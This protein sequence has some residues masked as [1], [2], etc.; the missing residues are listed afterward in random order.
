MLRTFVRNEMLLRREDVVV[1]PHNVFNSKEAALRILET[2][3]ESIERSIEGQPQNV[4]VC[5]ECGALTEVAD[6]ANPGSCLSCGATLSAAAPARQG[7]FKCKVC[8]AT[9]TYPDPRASVPRHRMFAIEYHCARYRPRHKGR[10][11]K[12]PDA[13]DLAKY[14]EASRRWA[15]TA[16]SF[17]PNEE[18]PAGGR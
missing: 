9:N 5:P 18:I 13:D 10:F 6:R 16:P 14:A 17:V 3:A 1:T 12:K 11:F 8:G 4:F 15:E 2:T 7:Q